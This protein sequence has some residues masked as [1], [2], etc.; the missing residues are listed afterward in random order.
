MSVGCSDYTPTKELH[1]A[2][3]LAAHIALS[4]SVIGK[5]QWTNRDYLLIDATAGSGIVNGIVGSPLVFLDLARSFENWKAVLIEE[6]KRTYNELLRSIDQRYGIRD[7][8]ITTVHGSH[9]DYIAAMNLDAKQIGLLYVDPNGLFDL[10]AIQMFARKMIRMEI[11]L[12]ISATSIKRVNGS[13]LLE[14]RYRL[15]DLLS[16]KNY[17]HIRKPYGND[18]WTFL[19]LSNTPIVKEYKSI[20]LRSVDSPEGAEY[21]EIMDNTRKELSELHQQTLI[22]VN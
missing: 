15:K 1:Y 6:Q 22:E 21:L 7:H 17:A 9:V 3:I 18:Q 10:D 12:S 8:R 5:Y 14:N 4:R 2:K 16:L 11:L 13:P 20:D 19:L